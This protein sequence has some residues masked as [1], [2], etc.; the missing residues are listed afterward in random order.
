MFV[1]ELAF[2]D[3][4]ERLAHRGVHREH[5]RVAAEQGAVLGGGPY[6]D[7]MGAM[8]VL[9]AAT[10]AEA[11]AFVADD[12]YYSA[13]GVTVVSL[14]EWNVVTRHSAIASL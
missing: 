2:D 14:R 8:V 7:E 10:R 13:P 4:P 1:L 5:I 12:P 6:S 11:E 9:T 3:N